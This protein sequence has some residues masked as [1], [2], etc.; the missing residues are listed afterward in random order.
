VRT[1]TISASP[2]DADDGIVTQSVEAPELK[3][4][5]ENADS[6]YAVVEAPKTAIEE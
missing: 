2:I 1:P 3:R 6:F 5:I 4:R